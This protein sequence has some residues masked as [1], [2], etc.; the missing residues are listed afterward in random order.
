MLRKL[1]SIF[2]QRQTVEIE[3][4]SGVVSTD[5]PPGEPDLVEG[6]ELRVVEARPPEPGSERPFELLET[7]KGDLARQRNAQERIADGII[8]AEG[9]L[10]P[11]CERLVQQME[12]IAGSERQVAEL[13][14]RFTS[15]AGERAEALQSTVDTL[16]AAGER[17]VRVLDVLQQQLDGSQRSIDALRDRFE[18]VGTGLGSLLEIQR[19]TVERTDELVDVVRTQIDRNELAQQRM[20]RV[21]L[22]LLGL[23]TVA[24]LATVLLV[25]VYAG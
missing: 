10:Q 3:I 6:D 7:I 1:R 14:E 20:F 2:G 24:V 12:S 13:V 8:E 19:A 18:E 11:V 22:A 15:V 9:R 25:L 17:Q 16:N 21:S 5:V 4:E 23:G